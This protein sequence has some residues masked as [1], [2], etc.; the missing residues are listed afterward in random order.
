MSSGYQDFSG[1]ILHVAHCSSGLT[2]HDNVPVELR[3]S[4]DCLYLFNSLCSENYQR[5]KRQ[6]K[7]RNIYSTAPRSPRTTQKSSLKKLTNIKAPASFFCSTFGWAGA[8]V[9]AN[10]IH[11]PRKLSPVELPVAQNAEVSVTVNAA[12]HRVVDDVVQSLV[13][14]Q[15][16]RH[17]LYNRE[18]TDD[19]VPEQMIEHIYGESKPWMHRDEIKRL[20]WNELQEFRL[21]RE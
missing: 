2:I 15:N 21:V 20:N 14:V 11:Q 16:N 8:K 1:S 18:M 3:Q 7:Q 5:G 4:F 19:K 6:S 12:N 13:E 17:S 9:L 10:E